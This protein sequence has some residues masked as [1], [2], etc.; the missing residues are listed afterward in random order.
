M[1]PLLPAL[2]AFAALLSPV[3]G[4]AE[5][6]PPPYSIADSAVL[7]VDRAAGERYEVYVAWPEGQPPAGGWPVL[8]LLDGEDMFAAAAVT[9]RR[10]ARAG[11]RS[12]VAPGIVVAIA[13]GPLP[14]R[15][16]DYTPDGGPQPIPAGAPA[17]GQPTGG[18]DAYLDFVATRVQ[19]LVAQRWRIDPARQTLAGHSFGGLLTLYARL[20]RPALFTRYVAVSPSL[21]YGD[22]MLLRRDPPRTRP[23]AIVRILAGDAEGRV[24]PAAPDAGAGNVRATD[25]PTPERMAARLTAA[26]DDVGTRT[27]VGFNHGATMLASISDIITTAFATEPQP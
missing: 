18:A 12:G 8:Y 10:L 1:R 26:G 14:R 17:S 6:A 19:P 11:A 16:R 27:L 13:A 4:A 7:T 22:G 3:A 23:R 20:S 2:V 15:V 25:A 5:V 21:W 9:A 24:A